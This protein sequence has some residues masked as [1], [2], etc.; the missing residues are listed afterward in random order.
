MD[1]ITSKILDF[2]LGISTMLK[3]GRDC[4]FLRATPTAS[5]KLNCWWCK[6][7]THRVTTTVAVRSLIRFKSK[8]H[9]YNTTL[10]CI[11]FKIVFRHLVS[12]RIFLGL[13][14]Q[15]CYCRRPYR[16]KRTQIHRQCHQSD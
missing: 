7:L 9:L 2:H 15:R 6:H 5:F 12:S 8:V 13:L 4:F 1:V 3:T 10:T 16:Q 11:A 14:A